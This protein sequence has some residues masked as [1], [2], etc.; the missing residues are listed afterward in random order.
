MIVKTMSKRRLIKL[1]NAK[2]LTK[3]DF[4]VPNEIGASNLQPEG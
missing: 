3:G 1:G 2:R 4:G